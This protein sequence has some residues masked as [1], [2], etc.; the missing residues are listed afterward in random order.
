MKW[1]TWTC[2]ATLL[3]G[4]LGG[5]CDKPTPPPDL[6][7]ATP[8]SAQP[9]T[10]ELL[11]APRTSVNLVVSSLTVKAPPGWT[12]KRPDTGEFVFLH[13]PALDGDMDIEVS[14]IISMGQASLDQSQIQTLVASARKDMA[15]SP[16]NHLVADYRT[17]GDLQMLEIVTLNSP[18]TQPT[19]MADSTGCKWRTLVF[20]PRAGRFDEVS[21]SVLG[22]TLG[23]YRSDGA[24]IRSIFDSISADDSP[25]ARTNPL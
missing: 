9:T 15:D 14:R 24:F 5:G 19:D 4:L 25:A 23:Q 12:I 20:V 18:A 16:T 7:P 21:L 6:S 13:G 2:L 17:V 8:P 3:A 22:V 1:M 11:S 10:Q